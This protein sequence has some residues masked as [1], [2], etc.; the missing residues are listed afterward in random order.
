MIRELAKVL[1]KLKCNRQYISEIEEK[2]SAPIVFFRFIDQEAEF[3]KNVITKT[4]LG[5]LKIPNQN[6]RIRITKR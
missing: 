3:F 2:Y 5:T 4:H 6:V 1:F